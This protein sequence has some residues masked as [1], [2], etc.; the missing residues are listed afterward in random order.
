MR[1]V[2]DT[3]TFYKLCICDLLEPALSLF[4]AGLTDCGRLP[5]L[6]YMLQRGK[7]AAKLGQT[8]CQKLLAVAEQM[9]KLPNT[10]SAWLG[11]MTAVDAIDVGE[12]LLFAT[13][14]EADL[15]MLSGDKRAM[16]RI[17]KVEGLAAALQS[18][19]V[20]LEAVLIALCVRDGVSSVQARIGSLLAHDKTVDICFGSNDPL[21]G[22]RSYYRAIASEVG[23]EVLWKWE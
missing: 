13:V 1:L 8:T 14:A 3:D 12:A 17:P 15:L 2:V 22:L 5:A 23:L 9:P 11:K 21:D 19:V 20:C 18:K 7:L 4:N 16:R 10:D 6:P